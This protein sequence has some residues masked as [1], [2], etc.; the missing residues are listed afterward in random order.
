MPQETLDAHEIGAAL[1]AGAE[2]GG[3]LEQ[4]GKTDLAALSGDEWREFLRRI[5]VGFEQVM[6]RKI[7][8]GE[9]PF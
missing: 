7:L 9:P 6:R 4:I 3:Y 2:A 1:E 5:V 8:N